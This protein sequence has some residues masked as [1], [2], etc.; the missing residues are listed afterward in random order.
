MQLILHIG[1]EKTGS[2]AFQD[3]GALNREALRA[4]GVCYSRE[5]GWNNHMI[6]FPMAGAK[7]APDEVQGMFARTPEALAAD[8]A[9]APARLAAEV[10]QARA[11]GCHT[12]VLSNEHCQSRLTTAEQVA[13]L[14]DLLAPL[15]DRIT[16]LCCLRPQFEMGLSHM[17]T[18]LRYA[19][20]VRSGYLDGIRPGTP[21]FDYLALYDRWTA[22]FGVETVEIMPYRRG[23]N[24]FDRVA[25][26]G[27]FELAGLALPPR[28][29]SALDLA[30]FRLRNALHALHGPLDPALRRPVN[31]M[32]NSM[33]VRTRLEPGRARAEEIQQR[34]ATD[35][36]AL[37]A[38]VPGLVAAD[39]EIDP[40]RYAVEGNLGA[41][42]TDDDAALVMAGAAWSLLGETLLAQAQQALAE[43]ERAIAR[44]NPDWAVT[45]ADRSRQ[46]LPLLSQFPQAL[47]P[48]LE[49]RLETVETR[50]RSL[51]RKAARV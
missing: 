47:P 17:S 29:N 40:T 19:P 25:A 30:A 15:F 14:R 35:N 3:W 12:F 1:T 37:V 41:L 10:A 20:P 48:K 2:T 38:R 31:R 21:Y 28:S 27:G 50:A 42:D 51:A 49:S 34:F 22:V 44:A 32:L 45:Y 5:M 36:A 24:L 26:L 46:V 39:L 9:T 18:L 8:L 16:V 4:L 23:P 7:P 13:R 11:D 33:E 6:L 43:A